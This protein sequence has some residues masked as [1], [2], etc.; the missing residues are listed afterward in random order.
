MTAIETGNLKLIGKSRTS[1]TEMKQGKVCY[2][3]V[4]KLTDLPDIMEKAA[5][6]RGATLM[7]KW[8]SSDAYAMSDEEKR[9]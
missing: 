5:W 3:D 9:G 7:R 2:A 4:F 6:K 8:L 1:P